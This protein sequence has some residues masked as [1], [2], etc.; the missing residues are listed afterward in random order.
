MNWTKTKDEPVPRDGKFTL[1]IADKVVEWAFFAGWGYFL[2][3]NNEQ[4]PASAITHWLRPTVPRG[5]TVRG[6]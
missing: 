3:E 6:K 1:V 4:I 2:T 5:C